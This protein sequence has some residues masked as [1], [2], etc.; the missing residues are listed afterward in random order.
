VT[1]RIINGDCRDV[2]R[3]LPDESVHCVVTSPPYWERSRRR[4]HDD[5][6]LFSMRAAE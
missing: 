4:I 5:A 2:L 6:P 3:T 1:I